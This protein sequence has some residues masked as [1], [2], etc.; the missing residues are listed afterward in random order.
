MWRQLLHQ[1]LT[2]LFG[3][4]VAQMLVLPPLIFSLLAWWRR[5]MIGG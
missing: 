2:V 4:A 1:R 3:L 5:K